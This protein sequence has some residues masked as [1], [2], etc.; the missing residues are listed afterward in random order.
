M[1]DLSS[2]LSGILNSPE[3]M[4]QLKNMA[5]ALFGEQK[6]TQESTP[7]IGEGL[8]NVSP[9]EI[10]G[11]MKMMSLLKSDQTDQRAKLLLSIRPHLSEHRQK[12]VDDAVKILR[13]IQILPAVKEAGIF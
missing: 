3:G 7:F 11:I 2:M 9:G 10:A 5:G 8:P 6:S 12:R 1:D 4:E 13:L